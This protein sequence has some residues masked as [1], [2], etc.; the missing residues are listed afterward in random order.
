MAP[1]SSTEVLHHHNP[2]EVQLE[3]GIPRSSNETGAAPQAR[4]VEQI[5]YQLERLRLL[6]F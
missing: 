3:L 6:S 5:L 1:P 4:F 2:P